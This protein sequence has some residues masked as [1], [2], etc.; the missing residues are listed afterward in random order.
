MDMA[1]SN[2]AMSVGLIVAAFVVV[3]LLIGAFAV[4]IRVKRRES[5]PPTPDEQPHLPPGGPVRE[6]Q[7]TRTA[8]EVPRSDERMLPHDL[9]RQGTRSAPG[10]PRRRWDEG[11]SGSFGSGGPGGGH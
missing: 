4:G 1:A 7:E 10:Q 11:S 2:G 5:P 9:H 8:E 3:A 6:T